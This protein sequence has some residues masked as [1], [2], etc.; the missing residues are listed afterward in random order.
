MNL[1]LHRAA[2]A[3]YGDFAPEHCKHNGL[4]HDKFFDQHPSGFGKLAEGAAKDWIKSSWSKGRVGDHKG[5]VGDQNEIDELHGRWNAIWSKLGGCHRDLPTQWHMA[6]GMGNPHPLENGTIW[7]PTLAV[8]YLPASAVKGLLNAW[9]R[10][11]CEERHTADDWLGT[12]L[13]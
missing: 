9:L 6:I 7:H 5:R 1:P 11:W 4:W 13:M 3:R 10:W 2:R 12:R 8:P